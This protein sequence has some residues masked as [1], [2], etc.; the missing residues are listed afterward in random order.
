MSVNKMDRILFDLMIA[1][2]FGYIENNPK[3]S[4]ALFKAAKD[5]LE[6]RIAANLGGLADQE[7]KDFFNNK[8]IECT[9]F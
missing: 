3:E 5:L 4:S 8:L 9:F 7:A 2:G 6:Q 1:L